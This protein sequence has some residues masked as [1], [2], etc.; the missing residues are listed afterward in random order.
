MNQKYLH[1]EE[2]THSSALVLWD[3][4]EK[5]LQPFYFLIEKKFTCL[6]N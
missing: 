5:D 4:H 1:T 2:K 3:D 6:H